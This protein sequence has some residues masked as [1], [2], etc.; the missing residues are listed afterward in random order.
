MLK[1]AGGT[2]DAKD[3]AGACWIDLLSPT[4]EEI[5]RVEEVCGVE[6]PSREKLS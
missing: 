4:D 1:C 2:S 3:L 6:L 5:A